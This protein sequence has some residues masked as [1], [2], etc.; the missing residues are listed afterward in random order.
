MLINETSKLVQV[1]MLEIYSTTSKI[2][3]MNLQITKHIET[4]EY[5]HDFPFES[6][7]GVFHHSSEMPHSK[8]KNLRHKWAEVHCLSKKK[9]ATRLLDSEHKI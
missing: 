7:N 5:D 4:F 2:R 9:P 3:K 8:Q 6:Y 1:S